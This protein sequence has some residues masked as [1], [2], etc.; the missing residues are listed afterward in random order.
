[1]TKSVSVCATVKNEGA[2]IDNLITDLKKQTRQPDEIVIV[3]G[4]STDGTPERLAQGLVGWLS[5]SL[6]DYPGSNIAQGRNRAVSRSSGDLIAVTDAG[7]R[8]RSVWLESLTEILESDCSV[9][10]TFGYVLSRPITWFEMVLGAV[11]IPAEVEIDPE[12]YPPSAGSLA[13]RRGFA[14][15]AKFPEWLD[16][17]ED[18]YLDLKWR[19][20]GRHIV[21][22]SGADVGFRP[23]STLAGFFRQY[24]NYAVGDGQAGMLWMKHFIRFVSY[25]LGVILLCLWSGVSL[26]V[27]VL[28]MSAY[29]SRSFR[30]A[31]TMIRLASASNPVWVV[32]LIPWLRVLGDLA[33]MMGFV[34]GATRWRPGR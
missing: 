3:D 1:M 20:E 23:R 29:F 25:V 22:V 4:G 32:A 7:L 30:R 12:R 15:Q 33:K 13:F 28:L 31:P 21:H 24:F 17:G 14:E 16:F 27:L 18:M 11:T 34:L 10:V 5:F 26:A 6:L 2:A 9:D 8:L 19:D